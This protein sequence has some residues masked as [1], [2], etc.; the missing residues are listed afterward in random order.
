MLYLSQGHACIAPLSSLSI[1][2]SVWHV[3]CLPEPQATLPAHNVI[4]QRFSPSS[5]FFLL[6]ASEQSNPALGRFLP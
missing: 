1:I 5:A 6:L 3:A 2:L 4:F